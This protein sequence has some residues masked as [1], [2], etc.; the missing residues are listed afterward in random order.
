MLFRSNM[1]YCLVIVDKTTRF[2]IIVPV[3]DTKATTS[4]KAMEERLYPI[5]GEP[6]TIICD[7]HSSFAGAEMKAH[8]DAKAIELD[9]V[10]PEN[11]RSNGLAEVY[12]RMLQNHF[13]QLSQ[14][15][16]HKWVESIP[17]IQYALAHTPCHDNLLSPREMLFGFQPR[18]PELLL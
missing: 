5:F 1:R 15:E 14:E 6:D 8:T 2:P 9:T 3:P 17:E 12:V 4:I 18:N 10:S 13:A 16:Q 11:H 7:Q